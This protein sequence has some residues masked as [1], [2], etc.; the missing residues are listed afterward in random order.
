MV[1]GQMDAS[2]RAA[3]PNALKAWL[4]APMVD[5]VSAMKQQ[6][7]LFGR[8]NDPQNRY[9]ICLTCGEVR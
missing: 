6:P 5:V 2:V 4:P 1:L 3:L 7:G 9:A 8:L